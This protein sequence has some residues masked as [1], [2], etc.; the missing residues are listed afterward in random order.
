MTGAEEYVTVFLG[1]VLAS[2]TQGKVGLARILSCGGT[3]KIEADDEGSSSSS[4]LV[5][6]AF[7]FSSQCFISR[8]KQFPHGSS[9][10]PIGGL[11]LL[12]KIGELVGVKD[13]L[14]PPSEGVKLSPSPL[15]E[16]SDMFYLK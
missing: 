14:E 4:S 7:N 6:S 5:F 11:E 13:P 9:W 2:E 10:L 3:E 1:V 16:F 12:T 8:G 15:P